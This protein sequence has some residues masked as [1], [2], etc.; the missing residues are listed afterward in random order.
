[1]S[2]P[3]TATVQVRP[4]SD[5]RHQ[6]VTEKWAT[7]PAVPID[8][9]SDIYGNPIKRLV[10]PAGPLFLTYDAVVAVPDEPDPDALAAPQAPVDEIPGEILH[11]TLPS[12][13]CLSDQLMSTAWEL[14]GNTQPGGPRVQAICDWVQGNIAFKYGTSN[15]MTTAVDVYQGRIGVCRDLEW[16]GL[17]LDPARNAEVKGETRVSAD[18]SRIEVWVVPTNEELVVAR[19][20]A[21]LMAGQPHA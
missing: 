11:F 5:A 13:Y 18:D 4:R 6:L 21:A 19:Q 3:T 1:V 15:P 20:A 17:R 10:M 2:A 16:A 9:Y 7:E 12:R 14:F 8:E